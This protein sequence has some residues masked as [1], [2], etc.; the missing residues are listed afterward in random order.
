MV[1]VSKFAHVLGLLLAA[2]ACLPAAVAPVRA[3]AVYRSD[4]ADQKA[5]AADLKDWSLGEGRFEIRDGWLTVV[6]DRSNPHAT[7]K[8]HHDGDGTFR[9]TVRGAALCHR[10]VVQA[11]GVYRL[12]VNNQ[13]GQL[14]LHRQIGGQWKLVAAG[15]RYLD[16]TRR[17]DRF[18]LRLTFAGRRVCGFV[19]DKKLVEYDDPAAVPPGGQFALAGGWGS[20]VAWR[21][22]QLSDQPDLSAGHER[23]VTVKF[24][25]PRRGCG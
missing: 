4:W 23:A 13:F 18:E 19:D 16:Y 22:I 5:G 25:S 21:D 10:T 20:D 7:L 9:A 1:A 6:S 12:E 8:I 17:R 2:I 14:Q 11:R 3:G 15:D 24:P